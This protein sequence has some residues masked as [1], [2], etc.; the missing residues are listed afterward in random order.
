MF[1]FMLL[2]FA[3]GT[4]AM[5]LIRPKPSFENARPA[6]LGD[7]S[8]PTATE[9]R[10]VPLIWGKVKIAGPNVIWYG[11]LRTQAITEE[12][13]T[14]WFSSETITKGYKYYV[15][16]HFGVCR[17]PNV[18]WHNFLVNEKNGWS[19]NVIPDD[20]GYGGGVN[21]ANLLGGQERGQG[22]MGGTLRMYAG[23][24]T[25]N[26][27]AY[28][29]GK[30]NPDIAY[31][32]TAHAVWEGGWVGNSTSIPPYA[33]VVSRI[34]DGLNLES[35]I[36]A[37]GSS[38]YN[39]G[40]NPMNV[41]Y[42]ILTDTDWGLQI[43]TSD[44]DLSN[45]REVAET[46]HDEGNGF[47]MV[48]DNPMKVEDILNELQRQI[49]GT[50]YFDRTNALWRVKLVRDDYDPGALLEFDE[51]NTVELMEY[52]R[53]TWEETTNQVRIKYSDSTKNWQ[54]TFALAQDIA[55]IS[56]QGASVA[57]EAN[58]PG[59]QNAALANNL[60]WRDL[61]VLAF[62]LGKIQVKFNREG[63]SLIVGS[64][65]K[66]SNARLGFS[67]VVWRVQE[68]NPGNIDSQEVV[69]SAV[70]DVFS[71]GVGTFSDPIDS[72]WTGAVDPAVAP[73]T[74]DTLVV[75]APRQLVIRADRLQDLQPRVVLGA[76]W[77]GGGT[78]NFQIWSRVATS[79]TGSNPLGGAF[80][81]DGAT[82]NGF[83]LKGKLDSA[84]DAYGSSATRPDNSYFID[85]AEDPDE[86]T[87]LV[88]SGNSSLVR[89]LSQVI[90][91]DGEYIG[92]TN[93]S[94]LG[95]GVVRLSGLYRGLFHTA[96]KAHAADAEVWFPGQGS[97]LSQVVF[98]TTSYDEADF[99]LRSQD[100]E[101][102]M[103]EGDIP[104][105][106][107]H[108]DYIWFCPLAPRDPVLHSSYA[109]SSATLDTQ[110]VSETGQAADDSKA[111][112]VA[113][114]PRAWRVDDLLDD[115]DLDES[116]PSFLSDDPEFDFVL[117]LDPDGTPT[118]LDAVTVDGTD[119][120]NPIAYILRNDVIVAVGAN[121]AI[122]STGRIRVTAKHTYLG[123][124]RT[125]PL[126][127]EFDF[128]ILSSLL[129]DDLLH[130]GLDVNTAS[131]AVDYGEVGQY[132]FD[133]GHTALPSSGILEAN[134]DGGGWN[135]VVAASQTTGSL[136]T[137]GTPPFSVQLRFTQAPGYDQFFTVTGPSSE[138]GH[139]VLKA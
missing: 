11:S 124:V 53:Q 108:L 123:V 50:L 68:I 15:G 42:E 4:V 46:L 49:N 119:A 120:E 44:I 117:V 1:W 130:G 75:E 131:T 118:V 99:Q 95:G 100:E 48:V 29:N 121:A 84:I 31:R 137:A 136:T 77:P 47:A 127:M 90:Y 36:G 45:F 14:G 56:I 74:A 16:I 51:N 132:D 107:I 13:S 93:L 8:F 5:E 39:G 82:V 23:S 70:Q 20:D 64:V 113:V 105:E 73:A 102:V 10:A 37:G 94:D 104:V 18:R 103:D 109:P 83:L 92:Y 76:R 97:N 43:S 63:F 138:V 3:L 27:N 25:Q 2:V 81:Q 35:Y 126:G 87:G 32:G 24:K 101:A 80:S 106:Q 110:Y 38:P 60:A 133:I 98:P 135:T 12:V 129:T 55:N 112:K 21:N 86:L 111:L 40:C 41:I 125:N 65:F 57:S 89:N 116:V 62:P 33:F 96:P 139:G 115:D 6:G 34:P 134:V 114:T 61:K 79:R 58:Y 52:T 54:Q 7:F 22:G 72:G 85:I 17:G 19:G 9:G 122:P 30:Q 88:V 78:I 128:T 71:A 67:D 66:Y 26:T 91:I 59:C 69:V 28:L